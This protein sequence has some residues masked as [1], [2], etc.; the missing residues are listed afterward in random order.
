MGN[1]L[2]ACD[3][4]VLTLSAESTEQWKLL[5][6]DL[7]VLEYETPVVSGYE[8]A[9]NVKEK[10]RLVELGDNLAEEGAATR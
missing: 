4:I 3:D 1:D 9:Q 6:D 5:S 10:I 7:L 8:K 2:G